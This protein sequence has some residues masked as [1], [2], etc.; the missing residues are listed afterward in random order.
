MPMTLFDA[1]VGALTIKQ[2]QSADFSPGNR[3]EAARASAGVA[4]SAHYLTLSEPRARWSSQDIE[5]VLAAVDELAGLTVANGTITIPWRVRSSGASFVSGSTN[6]SLGGSTC[7]GTLIPVTLTVNQDQMA[8]VDLEL[9]FRSS[10]GFT[11]PLAYTASVSLSDPSF[12]DTF[13]LGPTALD[14][15][16]ITSVVGYTVNFGIG[17]ELQRTDGAVYPNDIYLPTSDPYVDVRFRD[18]ALLNTH[19]PIFSSGTSAVFSLIKNA[20]GG[21]ITALTSEEHITITLDNGIKSVENV[22]GQ[23]TGIVEPTLRLWCQSLTVATGAA[24]EVA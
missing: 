8:T 1:T 17:S 10:D 20:P 15:T 13:R 14:G 3:V 24:L 5:T 23:G 9:M 4:P 19:G 6:I 12:T 11:A 18:Q 22:S 7:Y 2:C 16:D 21:T